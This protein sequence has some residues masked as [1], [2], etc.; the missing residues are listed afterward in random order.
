MLLSDFIGIIRIP[1]C[2]KYEILPFKTEVAM[3]IF[4]LF[5]LL[6]MLSFFLILRFKSTIIKSGLLLLKFLFNRQLSNELS[7]FI[8][9]DVDIIASY[10]DLIK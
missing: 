5:I 3:N 4:L 9:F 8:D 6:N 10:S 1:L 7:R 2:L